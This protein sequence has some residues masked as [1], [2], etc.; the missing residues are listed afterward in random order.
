MHALLVMYNLAV[1]ALFEGIREVFY[2]SENAAD[3]DA[4][5]NRVT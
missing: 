1:V 5:D 2:E 3:A 4:S